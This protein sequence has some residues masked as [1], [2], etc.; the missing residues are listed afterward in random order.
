LDLARLSFLFVD[1]VYKVGIGKMANADVNA[2]AEVVRARVRAQANADADAKA[3]REAREREQATKLLRGIAEAKTKNEEVNK[4]AA[5]AMA[6]AMAEAKAAAAMA[7][8]ENAFA[9][10]NAAAARRKLE[11]KEERLRSVIANSVPIPTEYLESNTKSVPKKSDETYLTKMIEDLNPVDAKDVH[12]HVI[13]AESHGLKKHDGIYVMVIPDSFLGLDEEFREKYRKYIV[14]FNIVFIRVIQFS[15]KHG[16]RNVPTIEF[17]VY[18]PNGDIITCEREVWPL[19]SPDGMEGSRYEDIECVF[20]LRLKDL[21][22]SRVKLYKPNPKIN[23]TDKD[24]PRQEL[25]LKSLPNNPENS[26][27]AAIEKTLPGW[28]N[29]DTSSSPPTLDTLIGELHPTLVKDPPT[30]L[31]IGD[32]CLVKTSWNNKDQLKSVIDDMLAKEPSEKRKQIIQRNIENHSI[33][34]K[35]HD[36]ITR[37]HNECLYGSKYNDDDDELTK[38]YQSY[39]PWSIDHDIKMKEY[40]EKQE[41][42]KKKYPRP[43]EAK[44]KDC[45]HYMTEIEKL[46]RPSGFTKEEERIR[47]TYTQFEDMPP[48]FFIKVIAI[49]DDAIR[50]YAYDV[51]TR[52]IISGEIE[53]KYGTL[54]YNKEFSLYFDDGVFQLYS[55]P[56]ILREGGIKPLI[57]R[58]GSGGKLRSAKKTSKRRSVKSKPRYYRRSV[59]SINHRR[60]KTTRRRK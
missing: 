48:L 17:N 35:K 57:E 36:E 58:V 38:L 24:D 11:I 33:F 53:M 1:I 30:Q 7:A 60:K 15:T 52:R 42:F 37:N 39:M 21:V 8:K 12:V 50:C 13:D 55:F 56:K 59:G 2:A 47:E 16:D 14:P 28:M 51:Q 4:A 18:Y 25:Q 5:A 34:R 3:A 49:R 46:E 10:A 19:G 32:F 29:Y 40:F 9:S 45:S 41:A 22:E 27:V 20:D 44:K 54:T 43:D 23:D 31:K 6:E 26:P